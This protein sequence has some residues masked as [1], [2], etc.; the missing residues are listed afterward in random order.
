MDQSIS[1]RVA[2]SL[3]ELGQPIPTNII[4]TMLMKDG[5]FVGWKFRYDS[6]Y[7]IL[8]IGGNL[9]ELFDEQ[10]ALLKTVVLEVG[11]AAAA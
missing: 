8:H 2:A 1:Q 3:S 7:A 9:I 10:G 11:T 4:Q 6:G 5:Y